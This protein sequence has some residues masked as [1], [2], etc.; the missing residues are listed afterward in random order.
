MKAMSITDRLAL[1]VSVLIF[2]GSAWVALKG[3]AAPVPLH[4]DLS[5][6][7]DRY[8]S[9]Y[10]LAAVLGALGVLN[11]IV[12]F[13][14]G[15]QAKAA[16]DPVRRKA[17]QNGQLV[18]VVIMA[19]VAALI[20]WASLG[21]QAADGQHALKGT[22]FFLSAISLLMGA[23]L[24][25]VGPNAFIGVKTPWAYKS[26]LAWDK[27]NRLAGRLMFWI[28]VAGLVAAPFAP[29]ALTVSFLI[30]GLIGA[31]VWSIYES[32]RVWRTDPE[33]QSF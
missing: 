29:T 27:S 31:A 12:A 15:Q 21:P 13:L 26:R 22:A 30:T 25:K 4:F 23:V 3:P 17:L 33:A 1:A 32:W 5:G 16:T 11:L 9:R 10:E 7:A 28:G 24:G 8:G 19:G 2:A 18:S 20:G 14:T 6:Q